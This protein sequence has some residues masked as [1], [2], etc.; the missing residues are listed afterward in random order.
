MRIFTRL[1]LCFIVLSIVI[2]GCVVQSRQMNGLLELIKE[3]PID[4]A[5]NSW[6]ARYSNY[7][8][9]VYAVS[10]QEGTLFSNNFGDQV[11]FDGWTFRKIRGM[12]RLQIN[13]SISD[14]KT[15]RIFKR[16][17]RTVL[18]HRCG[19]WE[20]QKNSGSVR[21]IQYCGGKQRY[22]NTILVEEGGNISMIRQIVDERYTALT[23]TKLK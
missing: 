12:G 6:L 18:N 16:G 21:Y 10:T 14:E 7:E 5:T 19:Q 15:I 13:M 20:Q 4:L 2:S 1:N 11:L 17:N 8:S 23:L 22:E 9:I 3:P